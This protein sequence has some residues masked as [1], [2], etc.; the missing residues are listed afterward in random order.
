MPSRTARL[1]SAP[2]WRESPSL[3]RRLAV[4][5]PLSTRSVF[6]TES[7]C[8]SHPDRDSATYCPGSSCLGNREAGGTPGE[9]AGTK[10]NGSQSNTPCPSSSAGFV[11]DPAWSRS[12]SHQRLSPWLVRLARQ[13]HYTASNGRNGNGVSWKERLR[14][15]RQASVLV[16]LGEG[17]N[18]HVVP[19]SEWIPPA[20]SSGAG[21]RARASRRGGGAQRRLR[22]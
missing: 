16:A 1:Q 14:S 15:A 11:S 13:L 22:R 7:S 2:G 6:A 19:L 17:G 4:D 3:A 10:P 18:A 5:L 9:D 21:R 12:C 20:G 8:V